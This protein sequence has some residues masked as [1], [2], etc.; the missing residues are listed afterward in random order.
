[1]I[2]KAALLALQGRHSLH[3]EAPFGA[4]F[5]KNVLS[6]YPYPIM[7]LRFAC[8][9]FRSLRD[10]QE[11]SLVAGSAH[12]HE[13]SL[14]QIPVIKSRVLRSAAIYG[15]NASGKSNIVR[16]ISFLSA[17]VQ[18]SHSGT[19]SSKIPRQRF[20]LDDEANRPSYFE[21]DFLLKGE[22]FTYGFELNDQE[23]LRE[24]LYSYPN[25][26]RVLWY[27]RRHDSPMVFGRSLMGRNRVIES[28][29]R[30]NS[31]FLSVAAQNN[32]EQLIPIFN[33][34]E[35]GFAL[36]TPDHREPLSTA[37]LCAENNEALRTVLS[38]MRFADLGIVDLKISEEEVDQNFKEILKL[39]MK[40]NGTSD[41][42]TPPPLKLRK[43]TLLHEGRSRPYEI[44]ATDESKGT[45]AFF[46]LLGPILSALSSGTVLL[47][48]ELDSSLHPI[49]AQE[50]VKLFNDPA[51]NP[52]GAQFIF[53]THDA[54]LLSLNILRRDQIWFTEKDKEGSTS[55]YPLSEFS[56]RNNYD[57]AKGYLQGR[58]GAIPFL[59]DTLLNQIGSLVS[60]QD[61]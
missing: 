19:A 50:I 51:K 55:V 34:F 60:N 25:A 36:I 30:K 17:A 24:W 1:L 5:A 11:L 4:F 33:W 29:T 31:L 61:G 8:K 57:I 56:I 44:E 22:R 14:I 47:I 46:S 42:S 3:A 6:P 21:C 43:P 37:D 7:L 59:N 2:I 32:H 54:N 15:A 41:S 16:A 39:F 38:L 12:E 49:L 20:E 13:E 26:R 53:T 9:N 58:F 18:R 27:E 48:D 28:L 23:F 45:I 40:R 35:E 10:E 52:N